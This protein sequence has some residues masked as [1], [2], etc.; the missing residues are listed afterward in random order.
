LELPLQKE[1]WLKSNEIVK[2]DLG[3]KFGIPKGYRACVTRSPELPPAIYG[4]MELLIDKYGDYFSVAIQNC[5]SYNVLLAK[6]TGLLQIAVN[7]CHKA[8]RSYTYC[9]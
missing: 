4:P 8:K 2:I 5:T 6:G 9:V 3:I 1:E 7:R